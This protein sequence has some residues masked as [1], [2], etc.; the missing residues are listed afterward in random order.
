MKPQHEHRSESAPQSGGAPSLTV[1]RGYTIA[2]G[3]E[4]FHPGERIDRD[5]PCVAT[6]RSRLVVVVDAPKPK[7]KR[8]PPAPSPPA[9][10]EEGEE[11]GGE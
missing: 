9:K 2:W 1:K 3:D 7:A 8:K 11:S 5:H 6:N 4:V 10:S